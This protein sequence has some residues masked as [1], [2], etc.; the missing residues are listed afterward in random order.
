MGKL[1]LVMSLKFAG[2]FAV[3]LVAGGLG[4][5]AGFLLG[6]SVVAG[7]LTGLAVV[8]LI[9][10]ALTFFVAWAYDAFDPGRDMPV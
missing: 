6:K 3:L 4:T 5:A 9:D 1:M 10:V 2:L 7:V 8:V